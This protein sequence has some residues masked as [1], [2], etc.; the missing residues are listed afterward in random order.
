MTYQLREA[1]LDSEKEAVRTFLAGFGLRYD[2]DIDYTASLLVGGKIIATASTAG[3]IIK[4]VAVSP[5]GAGRTDR[6]ACFSFTF[7]LP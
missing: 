4:A 1:I 6:T 3:N 5:P 7:P 2:A